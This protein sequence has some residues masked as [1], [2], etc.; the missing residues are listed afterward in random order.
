MNRISTTLI[1]LFLGLFLIDS[2]SAFARKGRNPAGMTKKEAKKECQKEQPGLKGKKLAK[3]VKE[4]MAQVP[5][6]QDGATEP[7]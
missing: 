7:Q 6:P 1:A 3:C 2:Q 4:K 5:S